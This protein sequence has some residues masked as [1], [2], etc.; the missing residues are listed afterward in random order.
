MEGARQDHELVDGVTWNEDHGG[1]G[2]APPQEVCPHGEWV[3]LV[4]QWFP[5]DNAGHDDKL[6]N[7]G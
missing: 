2:D 4:D 3:L 6:G 7:T 1:R 5:L